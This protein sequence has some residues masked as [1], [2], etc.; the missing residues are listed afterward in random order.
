MNNSFHYHIF[1]VALLIDCLW[2]TTFDMVGTENFWHML[3]I[4][5]MKGGWKVIIK[6]DNDHI[7][8]KG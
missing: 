3:E 2:H 4:V 8:I 5:Y 1:K 6:N 7:T